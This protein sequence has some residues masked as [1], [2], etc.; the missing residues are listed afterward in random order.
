MLGDERVVESV[1]LMRRFPGWTIWFGFFTGHWWALP[2]CGQDFGNFLEAG[3]SAQLADRIELIKRTPRR[4]SR[5]DVH[6][7]SNLLR[8]EG[9]P[10]RPVSRAPAVAWPGGRIQ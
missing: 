8:L 9:E 5:P 10:A 7:P 1:N 6:G 4:D 3:S 2:P